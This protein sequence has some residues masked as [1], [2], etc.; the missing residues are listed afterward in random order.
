MAYTKKLESFNQKSVI[1]MQ[2]ISIKT[3]RIVSIVALSVLLLIILLAFSSCAD[4]AGIA[5]AVVFPTVTGGTI[6]SNEPATLANV[7]EYSPALLQNEIDS[8]IVK[9]RP[10]ST[11][12]DQ[13]SR[14]KGARKSGSMIVDYYSVDT[15]PTRFYT[16]TNYVEPTASTVTNNHTRASIAVDNMEAIEVSD[17][18]LA[19]N[20]YGYNADGTE[21]SS[22]FLV[23][24]VLGK[25]LENGTILVSAVNGKLIGSVA[26]CVPSITPGVELV[27][28][29][30]AATELDVQTAQFES[31]PVKSQNF[32]Q[33]F[34]MQIEQS[35]FLKIANKEVEWDFSD[36]EEAAIYDMRL[37]M[38]KSFLFGV[39][40][41]IYDP[42]K[43]ENVSLTGGVW[44][45]AGKEYTYSIEE[46]LTQDHLVDIMQQCFT[47][48]AG[49][50]R[51]V[52]IAGSDFI[53]RLSKME[54]YK[55][56]ASDKTVT[57]WGIDFNEIVSKFGK[58]YVIHSEIFDDCDLSGNAF[59]FDPEYIQKWSHVP[60]GTQALDLKKAGIRN[61]D[62]LVI[63]EASCMTLRYPNAHMRIIAI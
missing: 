58:L 16:S 59:I 7:T 24:Y 28:M 51:K 61:T 19:L 21:K 14:Y 41:N 17:T 63:T 39:Q 10:M 8:R 4:A 55:T 13:I 20:H 33:I 2:K 53:S 31:L 36:Q 23:L 15:K 48:N 60:F 27:R 32:C 25:D 35:T 3:L 49:S 43:K 62:A 11:P 1:I 29:G 42:F 18:L 45:Q 50:K 22:H 9:I 44:W 40:K 38:E 6:V 30:R 12:I 37:S 47:G 54:Q 26:N 5:M 57:K 46:E 56:I 52:M 34:K